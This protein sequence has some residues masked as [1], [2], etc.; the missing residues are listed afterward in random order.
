MTGHLPSGVQALLIR[1][2]S[3]GTLLV[4]AHVTVI[5]CDDTAVA[6]AGGSGL[7]LDVHRKRSPF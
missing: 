6:E 1:T 4:A 5:A 7:T 3:D 2:R